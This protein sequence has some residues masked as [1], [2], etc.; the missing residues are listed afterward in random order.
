MEMMS[1]GPAAVD[2]RTDRSARI[3]LAHCAPFAIGGVSIRPAT[4]EIVGERGAC[5]VEPRVMQV[6]VALARAGGAILSRDDLTQSCWD[7]R[8]VGEDAINR[9]I[10]RL[11][12]L[13]EECGE[14][15]R[16]ET[17]TK[18]GY[19]LVAPETAIDA[20]P[21]DGAASHPPRRRRMFRWPAALAAC[22]AVG[23]AGA[24]TFYKLRAGGD[25]DP[26]VLV[27]PIAAAPDDQAAHI[28]GAGFSAAVA[29]DLV[30]TNT[31]V[32]IVDGLSGNAMHPALVLRSNATTSG[33]TIRANVELTES[34]GDAV[35]WSDQFDRPATEIDQMVEQ[36]S[37][38]MARELHCAYQD[39]RARMWQH[40]PDTAR[41]LLATCDAV[42]TDFSEARRYAAQVV[43]RA[44][45]FARGWSEYAAGTVASED[46]APGPARDVADA[47][48]RAYAR[49]AIALDPHQGLAYAA[50]VWSIHGL[51]H[52][53]ERY[54]V[55][56]KGLALDPGEP[57]INAARAGELMDIG[58]L[59]DALGFMRRSYAADH[60][61]PGKVQM[62]VD[63]DADSGNLD[64][65]RAMLRRGEMMWPHHPWFDALAYR[66]ALHRGRP[67][68]ALRLLND[69]AAD[70]SAPK[71]A[72][73]RAFIAWRAAPS[74]ATKAAA[75][76]TVDAAVAQDGPSVDAVQTLAALGA[77]DAA[78]RL[79]ERLPRFTDA[80]GSWYRDYLAPFRDDP[81]FM[82]LAARLGLAQIWRRSGLWPDFCTDPGLRY[83]CKSAA[84]RALS[85]A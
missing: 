29:R 38:Q 21:A 35:L 1:S 25:A 75:I 12:R 80:G 24:A 49:R 55:E 54:A 65:A 83:D 26:L 17:I 73:D 40:D 84:D 9:V 4:R 16:I 51:D 20:R 60:F 27:E 62:L 43:A 50:F 2:D 45:D 59:Q 67:A 37:L 68:D 71:D 48:T 82:T 18:V 32:Q 5:V 13:A 77:I 7:N 28:L 19:R 41:L 85:T 47:E 81:R 3:D 10:S 78:Y 69:G 63:L 76:R 34:A 66:L 44:P 8:V 74:P 33:G 36:V 58:R 6:L 57:E 70:E 14:A 61:L 42:G 46:T 39:D 15:F 72:A 52:W 53:F 22:A 64:D 56:S 11:R 30:G 79:A 31:P 23:A